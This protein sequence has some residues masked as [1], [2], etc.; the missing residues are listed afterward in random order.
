[1]KQKERK[2]EVVTCPVCNGHIEAN[3]DLVYGPSITE[4]N[5]DKHIL[6]HS[7]GEILQFLTK[8]MKKQYDRIY[9]RWQDE[10]YWGRRKL[11]EKKEKKNK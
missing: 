11:R 10:D 2:I 3:D 8:N 4:Q 1:M 9:R 7:I 5:I 6:S